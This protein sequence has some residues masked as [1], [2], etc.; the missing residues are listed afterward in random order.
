M[1]TKEKIKTTI[2]ALPD[3]FTIEDIIEE[4]IILDKIEQ[5]LNDVKEGRVYTTEEAK[6][7]LDKWLK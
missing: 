7:R 2:D 5:G 6:K 1:L 4:L 3:N